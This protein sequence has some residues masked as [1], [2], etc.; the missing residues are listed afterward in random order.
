ML[1][2]LRERTPFRKSKE[3]LK[4]EIQALDGE[5]VQIECNIARYREEIRAA[6]TYRERVQKS[7]SSHAYFV[8]RKRSANYLARLEN[9]KH[10]AGTRRAIL[11]EILTQ[12]NPQIIKE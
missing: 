10:N 8:N 7:V 3:T 5:I 4:A 12:R 1:E 11:K 2:K 9:K 6:L